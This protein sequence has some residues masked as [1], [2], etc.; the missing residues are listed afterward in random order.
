MTL[1]ASAP[2][3]AALAERA[4]VVRAHGLLAKL[5][6]PASGL[7]DLGFLLA[8]G[9]DVLTF[10]HSQVTN[11][12][13]GLKP[14]QGNR[15]ARVTRQG[16]LAELFSLHRLADEEDGPV[17][18]L[19]LERERVQSLMA[20]L[21]AVLFADRVELLDLSEDFD[22][23]A[24]QGPVADQV[25]DE[26]LEAEA[27]SFAAAPPEAVTMSS[28]GSLPSQTLLIRHSLTGDAGWLVL[29]SR[30]TADHTS[31]WLEGL[32]SVSRG[33]GLIEVTEP[34]LSPTLE[35]LRIEAG[36][37]RIGPDTS[38][39]KRILPET[40]LE[41]QTVSYTKGCYVGQEVIA[42]VRTYG[43]L[44]F[45]LRGLVLGRPVDGPFDSEWVELLA[46][47]PDPG[48]PVCIEDGSAIGQFASRTLSPVANA[49]VVYAYLDKKHRTPGSK[50]LL[51]LEGQ[52]VEAEVVLLPF[53][54]VPGATERVTFLY[55]KA[56][57]A[58]AQG[59][60]AK[61]LA[62]LEEA[63][64]IDPTFSD[65]Y[66]AIGVMLG[67]SERFHEAI[68]I[69]KRLEEI[70]PAEPMVN[71]NLSLYFMKIGDKETA[72]E[73]SAKAMQKSMAQRSGTAVDTERLD[74]VLSEQKQADARRKKEMFAQVLEIDS[75]DGVALFGLGSALLVLENWS[76]AADTLG[77]AQVV[78]P[79]NS[80][81]YLTRGKAL[82]R[83]DR[84]REAEGVYRA[85]ME[86]ASRKGDLMPLKEMEH[87]VLLLSG[88][89]GSSTKAFE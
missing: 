1:R 7:G 73:E 31:D 89:A 76:E 52:V 24:I 18:L 15:S 56:V 39:R 16:Q 59:Q 72:E 83:L 77:R 75:E 34:F 87:R 71:T 11:D 80:A 25:L 62:G 57:R 32:R 53:Y 26:W 66:E 27:G 55:D 17:V 36:L 2:E 3:R 54:D 43:K 37:V 60:E 64:R 5:G 70:A 78:D 44:P 14:G 65:G 82:E 81:I 23:W 42:R 12:V 88:Q 51:K 74:D 49:V 67:R 47:I 6:P 29:L 20:E 21:D 69:F 38:G 68:D 85:G 58:F 48:R 10:L 30:P 4:R 9:P 46:S 19:M 13:E 33:L 35:T 8:R 41:Q 40:G 22:A 61:A 63:L 86:V 84:A 28:S 45:A 79:D 50:L